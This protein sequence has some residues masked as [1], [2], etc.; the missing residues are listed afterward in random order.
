MRGDRVSGKRPAY[1]AAAAILLPLMAQADTVRCTATTQC[2]GDALNMCAPSA[3]RIDLARGPGDA[4]LWINGQGPY[5][6]TRADLAAEVWRIDLW[7]GDHRIELGPGE[8]F[9]YRGN[10]GKRFSGTCEVTG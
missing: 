3:L 6:A 8:A 1:L 10:R 5:P 7:G 9:L 4:R 2:R